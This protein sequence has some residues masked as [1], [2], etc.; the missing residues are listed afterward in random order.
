[1]YGLVGD[2]LLYSLSKW[3]IIMERRGNRPI[4]SSF[5][6]AHDET[7]Y[8]RHLTNKRSK[9][10]VTNKR[11]KHGDK[12]F[13]LVQD[14]HEKRGSL[15]VLYS[16]VA[17]VS[18]SGNKVVAKRSG[19]IIES[20]NVTSFVLTSANL[21]RRPT[22]GEF[23]END[24]INDLQVTVYYSGGQAY[25]G[26]LVAFDF[27]YNL[28]VISFH[29][30][31]PLTTAK[32]AELDDSLDV[33]TCPPSFHLRPHSNSYKLCPGAEVVAVGRSSY[34]TCE[35]MVATGAY[36]LD[37]CGYDCKELFKASCKILKWGEGGP[38]INHLGEVIGI[39]YHELGSTPFMPISIASKWWEY[40][41]MHRIYGR[42]LIG[43]EAGNFYTADICVIERV[44][45]LFPSV[46]NGVVVEKVTQGSSADLAGLCVDDVIIECAGKRVK[47]FLEFFGI[48]W[49]N[50]G[51]SV[52]LVI[53]RQDK[54]EQI[55]L[56]M[57]VTEA[58]LDKLYR[59]PYRI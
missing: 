41:K 50:I 31:D 54:A 32:I 40:F 10:G 35:P 6:Y 24:L 56:T 26:E 51:D 15:R 42:P 39:V 47:S 30:Q 11:S 53:V 25:K 28:A 12:A 36:W 34:E 20:D 9:P 3:L 18:Y 23:V 44:N 8:F 37:R 59:W 38:L 27:H 55:H 58:T 48:I 22:I 33:A 5:N 21:V 43:M 19:T 7:F 46:S 13:N 29:S 16:V 17:L 4:P 49:E 57:F 45:R 14:I 1:M 2:T 52:N